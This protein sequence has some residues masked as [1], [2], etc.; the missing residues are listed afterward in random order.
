MSVRVRWM[1]SAALL[2]GAAF[3]LD[4][5][6][7]GGRHGV[8]LTPAGDGHDTVPVHVNGKGPYPFILDTGADQSAV[9]QW[10]ADRARLKRMAGKD[11]DLSGQTGSA[12]VG[13]YDLP[14]VSLAGLQASNIAAYGLPNRRD[15]GDEAGVIGNDLMDP[16]VVA[17][18]FPCRRIEV[19]PRSGR[20]TLLAD[21]RIAPS[22][23][24]VDKGTT[25]LTLPVT[26]NGARGIAVLDT[27]SRWTRLTP[28]FAK[29]AG[30]DPASPGFRDAEP[31]Y[32]TSGHRIVP[33]TG[34]VGRLTVGGHT[35]TG[36]TA[37][38][39]ALPVLMQ[40]FGDA[41]AM[42]LGADV[43]G[44]TRFVYDHAARKV[45]FLPSRCAARP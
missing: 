42:L 12:R 43:L 22:I 37:Q 13:L 11:Q 40:D 25:L 38:V 24:G 20:R 17:F 8:A 35:I 36:L 21:T 1:A 18:D 26:I 15:K 45:W 27:G 31:I 32:G 2:A 33:R 6:I 3:A 41:P 29:A 9:Y 10:F 7:A 44:R 28:S 23:T 34:P 4:P 30:I 14:R 5:T 16:A 39:V 19:A